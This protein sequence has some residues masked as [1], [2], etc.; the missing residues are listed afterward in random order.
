MDM[1]GMLL[2]HFV[3][4]Y[5]L[6]NNWI[7]LNKHRFDCLGWLTCTVHCLLYTSAVCYYMK[8]WDIYWILCVFLSHFIIDKFGLPELY[9]QLIRGRSL[10]RF[11]KNPVNHSWT[12]QVGLYCGF[13]SAVYMVV[14]NTMHI[15]L[16]YEI[17]PLI[18]S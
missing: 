1:F 6:Q 5:L 8:E 17:Y 4:D 9:L 16:M 2:G 14:D 3:G 15:V 12:T 10:K 13:S 11:I 7:A 18:F